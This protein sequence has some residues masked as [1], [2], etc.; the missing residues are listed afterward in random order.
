MGRDIPPK[1]FFQ[2]LI[3][4]DAPV[5]FLDAGFRW[6]SLLSLIR[7]L[8]TTPVLFCACAWHTPFAG[9]R[10]T[11]LELPERVTVR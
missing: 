10:L 6:E 2:N 5:T 9:S 8:E 3:A 11:L 1:H 4:V 7:C